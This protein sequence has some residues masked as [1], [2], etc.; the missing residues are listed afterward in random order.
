MRLVF[1]HDIKGKSVVLRLR[2]SS[3]ADGEADVEEYFFAI[4]EAVILAIVVVWVGIGYSE[5]GINKEVGGV[6][7]GIDGARADASEVEIILA[8]NES[9]E[10]IVA[11]RVY[12]HSVFGSQMLFKVHAAEPE[13]YCA[14][15][16]VVVCS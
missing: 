5:V 11:R 15:A 4:E 16:L 12:L 13:E 2:L 6:E 1:I 7:R 14:S 3:Q 10:E 8:A 9:T